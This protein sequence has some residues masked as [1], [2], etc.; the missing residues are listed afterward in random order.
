MSPTTRVFVLAIGLLSVAGCAQATLPDGGT[1]QRQVPS[2]AVDAAPDSG[3][4]RAG[5]N[6]MGAGH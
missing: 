1:P 5:G 6:L 4:N 3:S 2:R